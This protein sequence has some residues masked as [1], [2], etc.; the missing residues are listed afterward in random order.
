MKLSPCGPGGGRDTAVIA[1]VYV[2]CVV[3]L[4]LVVSGHLTAQIDDRLADRLAA[5]ASPSGRLGQQ[6]SHRPRSYPATTMTTMVTRRRSSCGRDRGRIGHRHS[7][8]APALPAAVLA[9]P[10]PATGGRHCG[11]RVGLGRSG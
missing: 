10:R 6:C 4:N 11:P 7:P 3:V 9:G 2:V 5:T 1:L 8:G